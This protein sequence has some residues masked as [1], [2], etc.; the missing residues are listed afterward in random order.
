M[1]LAALTAD[2]GRAGR[3]VNRRAA[4]VATMVLAMAGRMPDAEL[5]ASLYCALQTSPSR[6]R[7]APSGEQ[8]LGI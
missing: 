8:A 3:Q 1:L 7:E 4:D 6:P 2:W 5:A